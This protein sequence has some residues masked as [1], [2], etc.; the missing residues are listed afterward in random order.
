MI[1]LC[2]LI[3]TILDSRREDEKFWTEW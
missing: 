2:V 3:V 1:V